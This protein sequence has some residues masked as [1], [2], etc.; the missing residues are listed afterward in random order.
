VAEIFLH[1]QQN[2]WVMAFDYGDV[3]IG[4]AIANTL[5]KIPHP[6]A[7]I[8]GRNKFEKLDKIAKLVEEWRPSQ[9]VVGM[10][11]ASPDK[12]LLINNIRK[13]SNR[14]TNKFKIPLTFINEDFTSSMAS[15]KLAAQSIYGKAQR[16]KLDTL[17][18]CLILQYF[19]ETM[20]K[21]Q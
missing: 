8:T 6:I 16:S 20:D 12:E 11:T 13:F 2:T 1:N 15:D 3:R 21:K 18:A 7:V 4:L 5:L 9:I 14:L 17:A 19:F 10:P